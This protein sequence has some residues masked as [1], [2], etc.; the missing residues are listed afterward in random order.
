MTRE[1]D[2]A[3]LMKVVSVMEKFEL[4]LD[5]F[6]RGLDRMADWPEIP[7]AY[8]IEVIQLIFVAATALD[9]LADQVEGLPR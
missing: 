7:E 1:V 4:N 2:N 5:R 6:Y 8:A 9:E 3:E